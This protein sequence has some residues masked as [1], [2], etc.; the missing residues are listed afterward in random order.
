M[1]NSPEIRR[2]NLGKEPVE[3]FP[4]EQNQAEVS[5]G[6]KDY[7]SPFVRSV[8]EHGSAILC[9]AAVIT[10]YAYSHRFNGSQALDQFGRRIS[11]EKNLDLL[12]IFSDIAKPL[13]LVYAPT[14]AI[15]N[16]PLD[17]LSSL[18]DPENDSLKFISRSFTVLTALPITV[19]LSNLEGNFM[20]AESLLGSYNN[21][22]LYKFA[23]L[24]L[25]SIAGGVSSYFLSKKLLSLCD[26]Y[27][28]SRNTDEKIFEMPLSQSFPGEALD[29]A[30][31][32]RRRTE[33]NSE[34][35]SIISAFRTID[36][37]FLKLIDPNEYYQAQ[38]S[39][40]NL[41]LASNLSS[42]SGY[43]KYLP[44]I[45]FLAGAA[46]VFAA[47][48]HTL[49]SNYTEAFKHE[50]ICTFGYK[51]FCSKSHEQANLI[52]YLEDNLSRDTLIGGAIALGGSALSYLK[53]QTALSTN[54]LNTELPRFGVN[55]ALM[56]IGYTWTNMIR[57]DVN[58][59][60]EEYGRF[61]PIHNSVMGTIL[62]GFAAGA[63]YE[64][65]YSVASNY[66]A[67]CQ[68]NKNVENPRDATLER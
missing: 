29:D 9:A 5:R 54:W 66:I 51:S 61:N 28:N 59:H 10:P 26:N 11:Y 17:A 38:S 21:S 39:D 50:S 45:K 8:V 33:I 36:K 64:I 34:N 18:V 19:L 24:N 52:T 48:S 65:C 53:S 14:V 12:D 27:I 46:F 23:E 43:R 4:A 2:R 42:N 6:G 47:M 35:S 56:I 44:A 22:F 57:G 37:G 55:L 67:K 30:S 62:A 3:R 31:Q 13:L 20:F 7:F 49:K 16:L 40:Q 60:R 41:P 68:N 25:L 58:L 1:Y 63:L 32:T 15:T